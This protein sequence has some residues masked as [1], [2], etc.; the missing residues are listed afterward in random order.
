MKDL[1]HGFANAGRGTL[2]FAV[3]ARTAAD[4]SASAASGTTNEFSSNFSSSLI[5]SGYRRMEIPGESRTGD[6]G[7]GTDGPT[8][9][10]GSRSAARGTITPAAGTTAGDT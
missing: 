3:G 2:P 4:T 5:S 7:A 10:Q 8:D 1:S 9:R 6:C